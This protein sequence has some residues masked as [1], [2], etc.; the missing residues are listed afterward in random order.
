MRLRYLVALLLNEGAR[1]RAVITS[2]A[3]TAVCRRAADR[4]PVAGVRAPAESKYLDLAAGVS[5]PDS[6]R[7][8]DPYPDPDPGGQK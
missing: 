7:S 5:D 3:L 8:V 2:S 6:I 4:P 1:L